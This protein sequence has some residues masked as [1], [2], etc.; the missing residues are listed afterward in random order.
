MATFAQGMG[1]DASGLANIS[2]GEAFNA[3]AKRIVLDVKS[4]QKGPQTES[5]AVTIRDTIASLGNTKAGNQF[6]IDSAR[7]L[8]NRRIERKEFYDRYIEEN[9]GNFKDESGRTADRA[10]ADFKR[11]TPLLSS[12]KKTPEGLPVFF[13]KFETGMRN[14]Y[15]DITKP[16]IIELWKRH[17]K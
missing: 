11:N 12:K 15:P 5:D 9:G 1:I 6:I 16:E 3:V 4:T 13:Y 10:W 8:N 7:A 2:K 14:L 17:D